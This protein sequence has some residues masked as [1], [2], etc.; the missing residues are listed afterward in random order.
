MRIAFLLLI[1]ASPS[2]ASF[3]YYR[4]VTVDHTKVPNTNQVN[5]P[6][7]VSTG[8]ASF[9]STTGNGGRV[10]NSNGYDVGFYSSNDC[11]TGKMDWETELWESS[12]TAAYWVRGTTVTTGS[13]YVFYM[14][15]GDSGIS[16]DQSNKTGVWESNYK[17]VLHLDGANYTDSTSNALA[18]TANG[19]TTF[20]S[21]WGR[22]IHY[23]GSSQYTYANSVPSTATNNYTIS[24]WVNSDLAGQ[25]SNTGV[26]GV[27][28]CNGQEGGGFGLA[29]GANGSPGADWEGL[30]PGV[31]WLYQSN[32][33]SSGSWYYTT[34]VRDSGTSKFYTNA[35]QK[36]TT[37]GNT[38]N[39]PSSKTTI[40]A[41][42]TG[43]AFGLQFQGLVKEARISNVVRSADWI[44]TEYNN[45]SSP[46]TFYALGTEQTI[47]GG[48][49]ASTP[50]TR[51]II[52]TQ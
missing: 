12:G 32:V 11:A 48:G 25:N 41:F 45:Q 36:A 39:T 9:L 15:Y 27:Y 21:L 52:I 5:F 13:D 8:P 40:G 49:G 34:M 24:A 3:S 38:P 33:F 43:S 2:W 16:S 18:M 42:Y 44:S 4:S 47:S 1:L 46:Y 50:A 7:L 35:T 20:P 6:I 14:C 17:F 23:N 37:F 51:R 28:F 30:L 31:S 26:S 10:Q 22:A 19:G 29:G